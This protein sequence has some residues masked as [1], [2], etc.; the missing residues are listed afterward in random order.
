MKEKTTKSI[1]MD[2]LELIGDD[3]DNIDILNDEID[4]YMGFRVAEI[5]EGLN[6]GRIT[7]IIYD[8]GNILSSVTGCMNRYGDIDP[9]IYNLVIN[10]LRT[11]EE[12]DENEFIEYNAAFELIV[13]VDIAS[14]LSSVKSRINTREN[15]DIKNIIF[16][17]AFLIIFKQQE[18]D[19]TSS[20]SYYVAYTDKYVSIET[21]PDNIYHYYL[22]K[23]VDGRYMVIG[24]EDCHVDKYEE[25]YVNSIIAE[26]CITI[27]SKTKIPKNSIVYIAPFSDNSKTVYD[28]STDAFEDLPKAES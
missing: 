17:K 24:A 9:D 1:A 8:M 13:G 22:E 25:D 5:V 21:V 12:M 27:C 23:M 10:D 15:A 3:P 26:E 6:A 19:N 16:N 20:D 11:I 28:P 2:V 18:S 4:L 7:S 14:F